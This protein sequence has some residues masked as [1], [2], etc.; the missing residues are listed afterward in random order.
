MTDGSHDSAAL[1]AAVLDPSVL[2]G[3]EEISPGLAAELVTMFV[4]DVPLRLEA[5]R[6]AAAEGDLKELG[7]VAH[8]LKGTSSNLGAA[9]LA[10]CCSA[11]QAGAGRGSTPEIAALLD[12]VERSWEQVRAM[13]QAAAG[14]A[15]EAATAD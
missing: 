12:A 4:E 2:A 9:Q 13:L 5:L 14:A 15:G 8:T 10:A 1:H 7:Q 11:L 6:T 3:Y